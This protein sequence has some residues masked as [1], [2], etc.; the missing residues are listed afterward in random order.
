LLVGGTGLYVHAVV[1]ALTLP[2]EDLALRAEL[3][4]WTSQPGGMLAAYRELQRDD[5]IAAARIDEHNQRRIVRALE[6]MRST[7][8]PFSSFGPGID[9]FGDTAFPVTIVGI[10]LPRTVL[11]SRIAQRF[12]AMREA[13]LVDEVRRL[14]GAS[15]LSRTAAQAIGYKEVLAALA[16]EMDLEAALDLAVRRTRSFA[17]RQRMWFRRDPRVRWLATAEKPEAL[18]PAL[19]AT[20]AAA[21][22]PPTARCTE[23]IT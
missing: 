23:P 10:W 3:E 22:H 7:G 12:A 18:A 16:D 2:G 15:T 19:L 6:V 13:G 21:P 20:W 14:S 17:R 8:K 4:A 1:D 9:R 11:A 5:P